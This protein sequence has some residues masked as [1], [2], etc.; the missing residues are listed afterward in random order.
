M[1]AQLAADLYDLFR[2]AA[3]EADDADEYDRLR[4]CAEHWLMRAAELEEMEE[5]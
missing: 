2:R 5:T 3:H 4:A 1:T